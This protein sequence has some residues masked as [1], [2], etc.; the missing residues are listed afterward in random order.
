MGI[1]QHGRE[2]GRRPA[3]ARSERRTASGVSAPLRTPRHGRECGETE[4]L[5]YA[6]ARRMSSSDNFTVSYPPH[7]AQPG[8]WIEDRIS[9]V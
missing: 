2:A 3:R 8:E 5:P 4:V 6:A 1:D 7:S 9:R